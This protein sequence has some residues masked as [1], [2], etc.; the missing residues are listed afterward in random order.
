M[1]RRSMAVETIASVLALGAFIW[2][3]RFVMPRAL[4]QHDAMAIGCALLMAMLAL[5]LWLLIGI[6][7]IAGVIWRLK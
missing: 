3:V 7:A 6:R 5:V 4:K 1:V 2:T